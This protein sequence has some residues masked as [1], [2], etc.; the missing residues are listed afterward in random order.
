MSLEKSRIDDALGASMVPIITQIQA[1]TS[2]SRAPSK[3]L[4]ASAMILFGGLAL[5]F[6]LPFLIEFYLDKSIKRPGEV[7]AK[8]GLPLF[9]SIPQFAL[10]RR[11]RQLKPQEKVPRL[12]EQS[13]DTK[14]STTKDNGAPDSNHSN[15]NGAKLS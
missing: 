4:K 14:P 1:R 9:V 8:L 7:E 12:Q 11:P 15:G 3:I 6:A 10:S 13:S 2:P 5:A